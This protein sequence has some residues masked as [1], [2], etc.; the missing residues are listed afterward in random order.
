MDYNPLDKIGI[1]GSTLDISK[2]MFYLN[3]WWR[4]YLQ[5]ELS[6]WWRSLT[7][8]TLIQRWTFASLV[9][10]QLKILPSWCGRVRM[11]ITSVISLS[12]MHI[13]NLNMRK[14]LTNPRL[15]VIVQ[16]N[17]PWIFNSLNY[18]NQGKTAELFQIER[19]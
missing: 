3:T 1:H 14:H 5:S 11:E 9:M 7:Y 4:A 8:T 15:I 19:D 2:Y 18:G 13:A 6:P 17:W 10:E 16:N 12:K